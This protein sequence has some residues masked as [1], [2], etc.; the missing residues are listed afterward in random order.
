MEVDKDSKEVLGRIKDGD[1]QEKVEAVELIHRIDK[2][3]SNYYG[4]KTV[5]MLVGG[6]MVARIQI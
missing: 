2:D 1:L 6:M 4:N 5:E 3:D